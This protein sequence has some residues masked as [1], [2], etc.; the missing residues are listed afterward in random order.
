M[1]EI[2]SDQAVEQRVIA[3][4]RSK[5]CKI[6]GGLSTTFKSGFTKIEYEISAICEKCQEYF[7]LNDEG[8]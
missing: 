4:K 7:Y 2:L 8:G 6:C 1:I 3:A 5:T